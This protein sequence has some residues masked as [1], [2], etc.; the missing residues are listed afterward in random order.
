MTWR[1]KIA[2][3]PMSLAT[4]VMIPVSSVRSNARRA[5][6]PNIGVRKSATTSIASVAAPPLPR[7]AALAERDHPPTRVEPG[8]QHTGRVDELDSKLAH[9]LCPQ[10]RD[11]VRL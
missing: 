9:R 6:P 7:G 11:L 3:V 10:R 4:A 2:S 8:A 1:R 5:G